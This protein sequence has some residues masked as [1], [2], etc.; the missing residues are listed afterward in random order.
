M[1]TENFDKKSFLLVEL[2][3][4][5]E[6]SSAWIFF[7]IFYAL[8][9]GFALCCYSLK[10]FQSCFYIG[11]LYLHICKRICNVLICFLRHDDVTWPDHVVLMKSYLVKLLFQIFAGFL[12]NF[13]SEN[14]FFILFQSIEVIALQKF[15]LKSLHCKRIFKF[16]LYI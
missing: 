12:S 9:I 13:Y 5:C 16:S 11:F 14:R 15:F 2:Q 4:F 6:M 3:P 7:Q 1:F 8:I 10:R